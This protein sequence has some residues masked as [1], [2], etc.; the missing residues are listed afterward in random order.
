MAHSHEHHDH[1]NLISALIY[2][3]VSTLIVSLLSL[4]GAAIIPLLT[5]RWKHRWMHFFIAMAVATLSSDAILH[6]IPQLTGGH[7]HSHVHEEH[8]DHE[9]ASTNHAPLVNS[10]S[11]NSTETTHSHEDHHH[12]SHESHEHHEHEHGHAHAHSHEH[13]SAWNE[14]TT[15]RVVLLRLSLIIMAI[16]ILYI[17]E[18]VVYYRKKHRA[19]EHSQKV[20]P[21][22]HKDVVVRCEETM[23]NH[24]WPEEQS[25]ESSDK[26]RNNN[27]ERM[28]SSRSCGTVSTSSS[29]SVSDSD[30]FQVPTDG[31][32]EDEAVI[33][34][35]LKSRAL[36]ILLGDG[37]HNFIDGIAIGASFM[38][39]VKLGLI[40]SIA[41]CM[42]ELPHE[43]GMS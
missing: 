23:S 43:L 29:V 25:C 21:A 26:E 35:G 27:S 22:E 40:T 38:A 14:L 28:K 12:E 5:G 6:I 4:A 2:G 19:H 32:Q 20:A 42:H 39:S 11:L 31:M 30:V 36:V 1:D 8:E 33:C 37:V 10:T 18:F 15:E 17:I 41:V 16:Y 3:T 7:S 24:A 34:W 9:I 13:Q